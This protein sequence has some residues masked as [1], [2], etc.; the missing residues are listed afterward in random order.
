[1]L[2]VGAAGMGKST[3]ATS[4]L[5]RRRAVTAQ[6]LEVFRGLPYRPLS[7]AFQAPL[8]GTADD[9]ATEI[10]AELD[11]RT[12]LVEDVH[13]ADAATVATLRRLSGRVPLLVT[14]RT[15][16]PELDG[17]ALEVVELPPLD[18]TG[19][20]TLARTIH[21]EL[22]DDEIRHLVG[23]SGG[24]PLLLTH[25]AQPDSVWPT[26]EDAVAH[27]VR[28]LPAAM[29]DALGRLALHGR[30]ASAMF[31][32]LTEPSGVGPLIVHERDT[33]WFA[34]ERL[35]QTTLAALGDDDIRRLRT[36]LAAA[37]TPAD[38]ARHFRDLGDLAHAAASAETAASGATP[39][40]RA[41]L[42]ELAVD[43]LGP[44]TPP[45]LRL[46]AA[47]ASIAAYRPQ[48]ARRL[49]VGVGEESDPATAAEAGLYLARAAWLESDWSGARATVDEALA[50]VAGTGTPIEARLLVE[51]AGQAV[52]TRVGDPAIVE[53]ADQAVE[54]ANRAEIDQA[55]ALNAAGLARSHS[56][57]PGWEELFR[58]A[59]DLATAHG[60]REEEFA[61]W[62]WLISAWGFQ[63]R[64]TEAVDVGARLLA[65]TEQLG[66]RRWHYH[67]LG[68]HLVHLALSTVSDAR[69]A[70]GQ[71]LLRVE[72]KFRNRAQ[73]EL[74]L[75]VGLVDRGRLTD[76]N[77]VIKA[78]R[79]AARSK[80]DH[81]ILTCAEAELALAERAPERMIAALESLVRGGPGFFGLNAVAESAG[82]HLAFSGE[83]LD[84][85][86][87]S[88][89]LTPV[90]D[91]VAVERTAREM[92]LSGD[93][94]GA[95]EA[96]LAASD[97]WTRRGCT[98]FGRRARCGAVEVAVEA[99]DLRRAEGLIRHALEGAGTAVDLSSRRLEQLQRTATR[100]V[101]TARLS[102]RE[103]Q[104]L[105]LVG[106]GLTSQ[107]IGRELDIAASTVDSHIEHAMRRL[108][109]RTRRQAAAIVTG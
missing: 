9:V 40:E 13:W 14:S 59:I 68:A 100:A 62:Y 58:Q 44:A 19:A 95:I 25:L 76:A 93:A 6:C 32:G 51:Q 88:S 10:A 89:A 22:D 5:R 1:V 45:D 2:I 61:G 103:R 99:G 23:V 71:R 11:R 94:S 73:V 31:V 3:L 101:A 79:A 16:V 109:A 17:E 86:S 43:C 82:L 29:R 83:H 84:V 90:L 106:R 33:V 92:Q 104:V 38:A 70:E 57:R 107:A 46:R 37:S 105:L 42:L 77:A 8:Q 72:P 102:D 66:L 12:L 97:E 60:D 56:G 27:R 34:H 50:R 7:H 67:F 87:F 36:Q 81:A 65:T 52:R 30:P 18:E 35:A 26:L 54:A 69:L 4:T 47:D 55:R 39:T 20:A 41:A 96:L 48:T 53:L 108:G 78:G 49:A 98:R 28:T 91:V 21:P 24:N 63:G 15:H 64:I 85:P 80:E 75:V 74:A